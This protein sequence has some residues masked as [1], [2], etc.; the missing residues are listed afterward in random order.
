MFCTRRSALLI[1]GLISTS[2]GVGLLGLG[3]VEQVVDDLLDPFRFLVDLA[4]EIEPL[5]FG[6]LLVQLV[7][8]LGD[9]GD[10]VDRVVE[11]VGDA[12]H[13]HAHRRQ[14]LGLDHL[15][16]ALLELL[17]HGV[18][19]LDHRAELILGHRRLDLS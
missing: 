8:G 16:L 17:G 5:L 18:D 19:G 1:N 14:L 6:Q 12:G 11:L 15:F 4:H 2:R 13:E 7:V 9:H 10:V 3:E